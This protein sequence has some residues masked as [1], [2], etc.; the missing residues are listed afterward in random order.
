MCHIFAGLYA[1][2][3]ASFSGKAEVETS[4]RILS[5]LRAE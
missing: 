3:L 4:L 2:F 1:V 5:T